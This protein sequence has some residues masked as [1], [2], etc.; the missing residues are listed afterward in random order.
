MSTDHWI[1]M[2]ME[3]RFSTGSASHTC[4]LLIECLRRRRALPAGPKN[5]LN[6]HGE[7]KRTTW[8]NHHGPLWSL[9]HPSQHSRFFNVSYTF[10]F[11]RCCGRGSQGARG[12]GGGCGARRVARPLAFSTALS[13]SVGRS[14]LQPTTLVFFIYFLFYSFNLSLEPHGV[15]NMKCTFYEWVTSVE[16]LT[17]ILFW[18]CHVR[19]RI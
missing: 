11:I 19:N 1:T 8:Q 5:Y 9:I 15:L 7:D 14:A 17:G 3:P 18:Q 16:V 2:S 10:F 6:K 13:R 4:C 12:A